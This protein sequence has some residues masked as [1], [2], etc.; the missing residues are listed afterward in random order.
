MLVLFLLFINDLPRVIHNAEAVLFA[1]DTNILITGTNILLLNEK[2]QNIKNQLENWFYENY[3]IINM[4][5]SKVLFFWQSRSVPSIRPLFCTND[6]EVVCSVDVKFLCI[7]IAED[8]S[9][10]TH[11]SYVCQKLSKTIYLIKSL[12]DSVSQTV[13][14][15]MYLA[16]FESVLKYGIIFWSGV[17][18]DSKTI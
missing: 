13:L 7:Y 14:R 5:K 9:W 11:T 17:L 1:D 18:K 4:D 10:S 6:K 16:N 12:R 8:L 15:N 3:L 2:I